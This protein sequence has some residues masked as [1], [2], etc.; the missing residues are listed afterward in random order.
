M[1]A[2]YDTQLSSMAGATVTHAIAGLRHDN[3]AAL[4]RGRR[5]EARPPTTLAVASDS[6]EDSHTAERRASTAR[7]LF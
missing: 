7:R 1:G 3:D 4:W 6:G 2:T 5:E